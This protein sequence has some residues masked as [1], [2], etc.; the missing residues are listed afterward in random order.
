VF[1]NLRDLVDGPL[2][3][4]IGDNDRVGECVPIGGET[5]AVFMSAALCARA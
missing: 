3:R 5:V 2:N 1:F 4:V